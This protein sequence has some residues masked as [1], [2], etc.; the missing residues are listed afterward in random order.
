MGARLLP[1][2]PISAGHRVDVPASAQG[3]PAVPV[4]S[5]RIATD[6]TASGNQPGIPD[7]THGQCFMQ[8]SAV[9]H[10]HLCRLRAWLTGVHAGP[11][12]AQNV[13]FGQSLTQ[14]LFGSLVA[15]RGGER[16]SERSASISTSWRH[17]PYRSRTPQRGSA[18]FRDRHYGPRPSARWSFHTPRQKAGQ[19]TRRASRRR[20]DLRHELRGRGLHMV[21][22]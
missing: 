11:G 17:C 16:L 6:A 9:R 4:R 18:M 2:C 19:A 13:S 20:N 14:L 15:T 1:F 12:R 8:P 21:C 5:K 10:A 3:V 22:A 7:A